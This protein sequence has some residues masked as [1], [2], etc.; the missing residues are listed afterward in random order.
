MY[1][2]ELVIHKKGSHGEYVAL[3]GFGCYSFNPAREKWQDVTCK[4][5]LK[6]KENGKLI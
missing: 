5:C 6:I 4:K 3:C 2:K 1:K